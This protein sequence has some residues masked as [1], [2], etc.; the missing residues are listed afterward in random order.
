MVSVVALGQGEVIHVGIEIA[1]A[2]GTAML[3]ISNHNIT[4]PAAERVSQ[5]VQNSCDRTQPIG[6]AFTSRT[7]AASIV[8]ATPDN[9]G[10]GQIL[11]TG[12]SFSYISNILSRSSHD[13][14][15]LHRFL[16]MTIGKLN[17]KSLKILCNDATVSQLVRIIPSEIESGP[18][19]SMTTS[20][21]KT[22]R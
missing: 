9:L 11:N 4:G 2:V 6:A 22:R 16:W 8:P 7:S 21:L 12:D 5:V 10:L 13:D 19:Y 3:G 14:S 15:L 1:V 17:Q 20:L 18:A